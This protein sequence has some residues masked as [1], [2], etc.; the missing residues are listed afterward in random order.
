[1]GDHHHPAT[2]DDGDMLMMFEDPSSSASSSASVAGVLLALDPMVSNSLFARPTSH[3]RH[4]LQPPPQ[5]SISPLF[6]ASRSTTGNLSFRSR[7]N[8]VLFDFV[9]RATTTISAQRPLASDNPHQ[10]LHDGLHRHLATSTCPNSD[11]TRT[12]IQRSHVYSSTSEASSSSLFSSSKSLSKNGS[13]TSP[14]RRTPTWSS[15]S[16]TSPSTG[17]LTSVRGGA[18]PLNAWTDKGPQF[19]DDMARWE[20]PLD[21]MTV[22]MDLEQEYEGSLI[23]EMDANTALCDD[24][25]HPMIEVSKDKLSA[26]YIGKGNHSY[27]VGVIR[28]NRPLHPRHYVGYFEVKIVSSLERTSISIGLSDAAVVLNKHPGSEAKS[29]GYIGNDGSSIAGGRSS[30]SYGP[31]YGLGDVIGC[32][33]VFEKGT[34]FFTLNGKHLGTAFMNVHGLPMFPTVGMHHPMEVVVVNFA[35]QFAFDLNAYIGELK[36]GNLAAIMSQP[37]ETTD[38][39]QLVSQYL[40]FVGMRRH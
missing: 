31:R 15:S 30:H 14:H 4:P 32:G 23:V 26:K 3:V 25:P 2:T 13:T 37:M 20:Q 24:T 27:D 5:P 9:H 1:M 16:Y 11:S 28:S 33:Y 36:R 22:I 21:P 40:M 17:T 19:L 10:P 29:Y 39:H 8:D 18:S 6:A 34:V 35:G 12:S 7:S 38:I